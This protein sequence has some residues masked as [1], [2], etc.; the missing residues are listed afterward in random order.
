MNKKKHVHHHRSL[1]NALI[2]TWCF[3]RHRG[4]VV[5]LIE[6]YVVVSHTPLRFL[7]GDNPT[8]SNHY[9]APYTP[10]LMSIIYLAE[11]AFGVELV[12]FHPISRIPDLAKPF[13]FLTR[14]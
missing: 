7:I 1:K 5:S 14:L 13:V 9:H 8:K 4:A 2:W 11:L 6:C 3:T 12:H 10:H